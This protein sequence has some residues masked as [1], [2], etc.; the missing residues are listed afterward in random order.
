MIG[1][2][3]SQSSA[4][5]PTTAPSTTA[6][7]TSTESSSPTTPTDNT[8]APQRKPP[9]GFGNAIGRVLYDGKGVSNIEVQLC[10]NIGFIGGCGGKTYAGKTNKD[11][12][13]V[14][15]KV[16]PGDYAVAV[17]V[18]NTNNFIYP[19]SGIMSAAKFKVQKDESLAVRTVNLWKVD[20]QIVSP[21]N[22]TVVKTDK[23]KLSWKSYPHASNYKIELRTKEGVG[24]MSSMETSETSTQPEKSLL[25][26]DYQW[27]VEAY[28][29]EGTKIAET[30]KDSMFKVIGQ[31]GSSAVTLINPKQASTVRGG[32]ITLQWKAHPQAQEYHVYVKG[33]KAKDP[34]LSF[35][36]MNA[37][38]Y[39]FPNP[40]PPD[41][42]YWSVEA[43]KDGDKIAG[44]EL[45]HFTV[46]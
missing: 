21:K 29:A 3:N 14:I 2:C 8:A 43:H 9:A 46:K 12:Y 22:G 30:A 36:S 26:G 19:T 1:G 31:A 23:P 32:A 35:E 15:D 17:R 45:Q 28:N 4:P 11:G 7:T 42:Y 37:T 34:L 6:P 44:S 39:K 25:N 18:F 10:E 41:D 38:S 27:Q 20:L 33:V 16:K 40:L 5:P 13:Y 24:T